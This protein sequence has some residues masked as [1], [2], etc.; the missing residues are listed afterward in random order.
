MYDL[1]AFD[2][3]NSRWGDLLH[4]IQ[5]IGLWYFCE[6][7]LDGRVGKRQ[8]RGIVLPL[9]Y[10]VLWGMKLGLPLKDQP[11]I[12]M[13][14]LL[15]AFIAATVLVLCFYRGAWR[16]VVFLI[17]TFVAVCEC[18]I[19]FG[20]VFLQL[21]LRGNEP[22]IRRL[23][24]GS[25]EAEKAVLFVLIMDTVAMFF[26][27]AM[28]VLL[29]WFSLKKIVGSF[30]EK[31]YEIQRT[32]LWFLLSPSLVS[33]LICLM[34]RAIMIFEGEETIVVLYDRY[35]MLMLVVPA[36]MLL[37]LLS[38]RYGVKL[39]QDM[40]CLNRERNSRIVLERQIDSMQEHMAELERIYS[41]VRSVKHD[42][43]NTVAIAMRLAAGDKPEEREELQRYLE[44]LNGA[45]E[46]QEPGFRTGNIVVDT[47]LNMKYHEILRNL[48]GLQLDVQELFFPTELSF[49]NYDIGV[50]LGNALD[51]AIE[52]CEKQAG[53]G[54]GQFIRLHSFQRGNMFF[55]EVTNSFDG[56][57]TVRGK[58]EFPESDKADKGLHGLG[59]ANIKRIA[60]KYH[61]AVEWTTED[62][63]FTLSVML[64]NKK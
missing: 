49:S 27:H 37:C 2:W 40:I 46:E 33:L 25:I 55:L 6:Y 63:R 34:L 62:G 57:V 64:Q 52:A 35:P 36:A 53:Q 56:E 31:A 28:A 43:K 29:F 22:W 21:G 4:I 59:L 60:E 7:F 41:G 12:A 58:A 39:F 26:Y 8:L 48:P 24:Q 44:G 11:A 9:L 45:L 38:I 13:V 47:L 23:E 10:A 30:R 1:T 15:L 20:Y 50:I 54:E 32:E 5:G 16:R 3:I 14:N 51:N 17:V 61:G 42:M 19:M 18:S